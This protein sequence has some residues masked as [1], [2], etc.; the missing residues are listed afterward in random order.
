[1]ISVQLK[2]ALN[3]ERNVIRAPHI[4]QIAG[5]IIEMDVLPEELAPFAVSQTAP[6][7]VPPDQ[8]LRLDMFPLLGQTTVKGW[9]SGREREI[10]IWNGGEGYRITVEDAGTFAISEDGSHI[11]H[12][13]GADLNRGAVVGALVYCTFYLALALHNV[14]CLHASSLRID[15]RTIALLGPS[16]VGKSTLGVYLGER[17][18]RIADDILPITQPTTKPI[19][20]P[21]FPQARLGSDQAPMVGVPAHLHLSSIYILHVPS[22]PTLPEITSL[23]G[24]SALQAML[25]ETVGVSLF[26]QE[27]LIQHIELLNR[28]QQSI[29]VK[30]LVYPHRFEFLPA[31]RQLLEEDRV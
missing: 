27:L 14:F 31:V 3:N 7:E 25:F 11:I 4:L 19:V 2:G 28:V 17:W 24:R 18:Q 30:Q 23:A 5:Q 15:D 1:M 21:H 26:T 6:L 12:L 29:P 8:L 16:G 13:G 22:A 20:L 9:I 10:S